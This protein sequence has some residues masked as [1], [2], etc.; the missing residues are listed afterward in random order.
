ML[1]SFEQVLNQTSSKKKKAGKR[2]KA[3]VV[4]IFREKNQEK[5]LES[6][7]IEEIMSIPLSTGAVKALFEKEYNQNFQP[8]LQILQAAVAQP[9]N[10][11]NPRWK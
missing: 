5:T 8:I 1:C 7:F 9:V 11:G 6:I 4:Q 10:G 3:T 2:K